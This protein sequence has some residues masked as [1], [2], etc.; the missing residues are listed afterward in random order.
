MLPHTVIPSLEAGQEHVVRIPFRCR[1]SNAFG[2]EV[3][4]TEADGIVQFY[5]PFNC[6][7]SGYCPAVPAIDS[8]Y[9]ESGQEEY[10]DSLYHRCKDS[11]KS[12]RAS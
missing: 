2:R 8:E 11:E 7:G 3:C 4:K 5:K 12:A 6:L 1:Q 9:Q 10:A